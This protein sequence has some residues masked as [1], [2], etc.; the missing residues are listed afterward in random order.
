MLI[1]LARDDAIPDN[2]ELQR[3]RATLV[4]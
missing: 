3:R 2:A 4:K 1:A